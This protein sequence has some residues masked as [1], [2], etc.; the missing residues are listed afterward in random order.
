MYQDFFQLSEFPFSIVPNPKFYYLSERHKEALTHILNDIEDGSGLALLTGEVGTGKTTTLRELLLRLPKDSKVITLLNPSVTVHE[1]M[2]TLCKE[3]GA[4]H[5]KSDTFKT[6]YDS[7]SR[8]LLA[9]EDK[10]IRTI[11]LVDEAQHVSPDVLEQLRLLTNIETPERKL[12]KVILIGQPE[13]QHILRQPSLRQ[14]SQRITV[15]YHLIPLPK[16]DVK[17]YIFHRLHC[18]ERLE[19]IFLESAINVIAQ[20]TQGVPRL[21][22]L[23]CDHALKLAFKESKQ[24]VCRGIALMACREVLDWTDLSD[25]SSKKKMYLIKRV[26][27]GFGIL[28]LSGYFVY[29]VFLRPDNALTSSSHTIVKETSLET[30]LSSSVPPEK[31]HSLNVSQE[32]DASREKT[33]AVVEQAKNEISP[34]LEGLINNSKNLTKATRDL[35]QTWGFEAD[36]DASICSK[37]VRGELACQRIKPSLSLLLLMGRPAVLKFKVADGPFWYGLLLGTDGK[38]FELKVG[39]EHIFANEAFIERAW[40]GEAFTVWRP[41]LG[42]ASLLKIGAQGPRV[43]WLNTHLNKVMGLK[44]TQMKR[45]GESL[46]EKVKIFQGNNGLDADGVPGPITLMVLDKKVIMTGPVLGAEFHT[47]PSQTRLLSDEGIVILPKAEFMRADLIPLPKMGINEEFIYKNAK[48]IKK[49]AFEER[50]QKPLTERQE[51]QRT[52][53]AMSLL[54]VDL[55]L[56]SPNMAKS[57]QAAITK[58]NAQAQLKESTQEMPSSY[59]QEQPKKAEPSPAVLEELSSVLEGASGS[60]YT[61]ISALTS[62]DLDRLPGLDFQ[63]HIYGKVRAARWIKVNGVKVKEGEMI[64]SSVRLQGIKPQEVIIEFEDELISI[65]ALTAW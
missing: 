25:E 1:L 28:V 6:L 37:K 47:S 55:S 45:F 3:L 64:T 44:K 16:N 35:Y 61:P 31:L 13:L 26:A 24:R 59:T 54:D 50:A 8:Q 19:P 27:A 40:T 39:D 29:G 51:A 49:D 53:E 12:L 10:G 22:N 56:L 9:N 33:N 62:E 2:L 41:V 5:Q 42:D 52:E 43:T 15:R 17:H 23:V 60:K 65:P 7:I 57:V 20:E 38:T 4:Q 32:K 34:V 36:D 48:V 11:F 58:T 63:T 18:A 30:N 21:I 14:L 46:K